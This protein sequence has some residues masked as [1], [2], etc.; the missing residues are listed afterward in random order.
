[1]ALQVGNGVYLLG[2][3]IP[4]GSSVVQHEQYL[5]QKF[6]KGEPKILGFLISGSLSIAAEK[7]QNYC[8]IKGSM[9][10]N[11][12]S[13]IAAGGGIVIYTLDVSFNNFYYMCDLDS[14]D[15][16]SMDCIMF[17]DAF[18]IYHDCILSFLLLVCCLEF[19][20]SISTSCFG[21]KVVCDP[22]EGQPLF[23]V[24]NNNTQ[25]P[26]LLPT[27][28][29]MMPL[30]AQMSYGISVMQGASLPA[31]PL[32]PPYSY[33]HGTSTASQA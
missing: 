27:Q 24:Q 4:S 30:P 31:T 3:Y 25:E 1:M 33:I 13:S 20:I 21:C 14:Q 16:S 7:K 12:F 2:Q 15:P 11:I 23:I 19:C 10:A 8:L 28:A 29:T 5:L 26:R 9:I 17:R 32:P 18:T 6:I 22:E